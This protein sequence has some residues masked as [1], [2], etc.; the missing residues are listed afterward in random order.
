M[1]REAKRETKRE[2]MIAIERERELSKKREGNEE[3]GKCVLKL[4]KKNQW[5]KI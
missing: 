2:E 1:K 4:N 5:K 3:A